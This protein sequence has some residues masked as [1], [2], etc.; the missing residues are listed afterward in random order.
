MTPHSWPDLPTTLR[1]PPDRA[2]RAAPPPQS[3]PPPAPASLLST[4]SL[5]YLTCLGSAKQRQA[6]GDGRES[7]FL[8]KP[9]RRCAA[10]LLLRRARRGAGLQTKGDPLSKDA[11][12]WF[13]S[14]RR[15][16]RPQPPPPWWVPGKN[17]VKRRRLSRSG[18]DVKRLRL[19]KKQKLSSIFPDATLSCV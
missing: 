10:L 13:A 3:L 5:L 4:R 7:G 16:H 12:L 18:W 1:P 9:R 11:L 6:N 14:A 19:M 15:R 17:N 8:M 2:P